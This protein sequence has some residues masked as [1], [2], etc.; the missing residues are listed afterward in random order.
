MRKSKVLTG[1]CI[2]FGG[3]G[4]SWV[5]PLAPTVGRASSA[6]GSN[7]SSAILTE[8]RALRKEVGDLRSEIESLRKEIRSYHAS[9]ERVTGG[10]RSAEGPARPVLPESSAIAVKFTKV[11]AS[12]QGENSE[13]EIAGQVSGLTSSTDCRIVLYAMTNQWYVQPLV[14]A[15]FTDI[16]PRGEWSS[17]VHLGYKYAALLVRPSFKPK[18]TLGSLPG[19]G[20]DV[21]AVA[22]AD[23][24]K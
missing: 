15:P 12:G 11:P 23:A 5:L 7:V 13:G 9:A 22:T 18:A 17:R 16:D 21:L 14:D 8:V 4:L 20:G 2:L 3:I 24:K 6:D 1:F 10:E 19:V